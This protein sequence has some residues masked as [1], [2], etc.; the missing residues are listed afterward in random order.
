MTL[1]A[2]PRA[3]QVFVGDFSDLKEPEM[4]KVRPVIVVSPRLPYRSEIVA[5]VPISLTAPRHELPFCYK[6][7]KN[8]HPEEADDLDCWAKADMVMNVALRRLS[9]FRVGRRKYAYP[10]LTP[11]DLLGVRIAVLKGLGLDRLP[12]QPNG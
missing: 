5:V 3:G 10:T 2:F 4:T 1:L 6:L 12:I 11:E 8:Y 9:A 7:S